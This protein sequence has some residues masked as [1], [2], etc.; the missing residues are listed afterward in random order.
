VGQLTKQGRKQGIKPFKLKNLNG[1]FLFISSVFPA[2]LT[3]S[4]SRG[5]FVIS[6]RLKAKTLNVHFALCASLNLNHCIYFYHLITPSLFH[7]SCHADLS[8]NEE[9]SLY[10]NKK[11]KK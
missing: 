10:L 4:R 2:I 3:S 1:F 7:L 11:E 8:A 5:V 9:A 6:Y